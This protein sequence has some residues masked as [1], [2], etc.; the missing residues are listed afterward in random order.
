M[1]PDMHWT[2]FPVLNLTPGFEPFGPSTV[3]S[4]EYIDYPSGVEPHVRITEH[5]RQEGS[6]TRMLFTAQPTNP[7]ELMRVL[8]APSALGEGAHVELFM[9]YM[10]HARQDRKAVA[11]DA[12]SQK[13]MEALLRAAGYY[14]VHVFDLHNP[15]SLG[16]HPYNRTFVRNYLPTHFIE[17][18]VRI[19]E[20]MHAEGMKALLVVPDKGMRKRLLH[21]VAFDANREDPT[22]FAELMIEH[23]QLVCVKERDPETGKLVIC[24]PTDVVVKDRVCVIVDD[25][26]DGGGTFIPVITELKARGAKR[27]VLAVS[28][29]L[30]TKGYAD[31]KEAGLDEV[32]CTNSWPVSPMAPLKR[33]VSNSW[34]HLLGL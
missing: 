16:I 6:E 21:M 17:G 5:V 18:V 31:L 26:C 10:P 23:E 8:L 34:Y 4:V 20:L 15:D 28:H 13:V 24:I 32:L 33:E 25:I 19:Q 27:V 7:T 22:A 14:H 3:G 1:I 2:R 29:G 12:D 11:T 9:P 30:F